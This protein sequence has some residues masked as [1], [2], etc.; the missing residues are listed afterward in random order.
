M[1][2]IKAT[3]T[4]LYKLVQDKTQLNPEI[5]MAPMKRSRFWKAHCRPDYFLERYQSGFFYRAFLSVCVGSP[6]LSVE[7]SY[8][9]V[10]DHRQV[11]K[12]TL[13][14]LQERGMLQYLPDEGK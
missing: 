2:H 3:K 1:L 9:G 12:L 10:Y 14:D 5:C 4:S 6:L 8:E 7:R 11:I 13:E